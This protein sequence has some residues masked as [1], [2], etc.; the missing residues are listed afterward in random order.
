MK[1]TTA[2]ANSCAFAMAFVLGYALGGYAEHKSLEA[3][4]HK[5]ANGEIG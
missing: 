4:I 2:I 3:A 1:I 5:I